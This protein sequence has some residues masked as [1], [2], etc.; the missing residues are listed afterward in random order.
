MSKRLADAVVNLLLYIAKDYVT[1]HFHGHSQKHAEDL[2][3]EIEHVQ[4]MDALI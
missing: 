4:S 3:K 1:R 2:I